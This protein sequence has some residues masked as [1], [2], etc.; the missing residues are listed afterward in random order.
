METVMPALPGWRPR[1]DRWLESAPIHNGL[2]ALIP[3]QCRD[4]RPE[5]SPALMAAW[6]SG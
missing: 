5:T 1:L 6:G 3:G 2:I 4:T